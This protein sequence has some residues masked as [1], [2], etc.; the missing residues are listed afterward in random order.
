MAFVYSLHALEQI[1]LRGLV[2][3]IVDNVLN[4][5]SM[6]VK[7]T[8]GVVI[9]QKLA[10]EGNKQYLYRVFVNSYKKPPMVITVYKTSKIDKYE[11][12]I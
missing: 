4:F 6:I 7:D 10:V 2:F 5:P 9:Y 8:D 11:N 12:Q 1:K 3:S